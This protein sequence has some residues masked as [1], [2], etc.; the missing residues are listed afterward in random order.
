M[1]D[2]V[3]RRRPILSFFQSGTVPGL[4]ASSSR[5]EVAPDTPRHS[6]SSFRAKTS[7]TRSTQTP[8]IYFLHYHEHF[9]ARAVV[10]R[11]IIFSRRASN[12]APS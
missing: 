3:S 4:L 7:H 5:C 10:S 11:M 8:I 12:R 1:R 6:L 2:T 9:R